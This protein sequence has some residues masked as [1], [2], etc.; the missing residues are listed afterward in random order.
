MWYK[1]LICNKAI[2]IPILCII[3]AQFLKIITSSIHS[4]KFSL[5]MFVNNGGMPSSH[6]S[7][8]CSLAV[9]VCNIKG[10]GSVEFALATALAAIVMHD[11]VNVR[12]E[13][14]KHSVILNEL[15]AQLIHPDKEWTALKTLI[16][17]TPL[18]VIIGAILGIGMTLIILT[19][20]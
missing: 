10:F 20:L 15:M 8:V 7:G 1:D 2:W 3:I 4:K 13:A 17:H 18:Q 11:A 5:K 14:G 6:S 12:G 16:G 9:V 19:F